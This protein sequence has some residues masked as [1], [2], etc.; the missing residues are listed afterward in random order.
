[1]RFTPIYPWLYRLLA[2]TFPNCLWSGRGDRNWIAL[3]FDDG[4]HPEYTPKLLKV[5]ERYD[6]VASFFCLG[7]CVRENSDLVRE[8]YQRGHWLGLHGYKHTSFT[9][10]SRPELNKSLLLTKEAIATAT[11]IEPDRLIDVRPPNGLFSPAILKQLQQL[12]YR[13]VMW[14]LVSEDWLNPG[15]EIIRTRVINGVKNGAN[16]VLHDG[17]YGGGKDVAAVVADLIPALLDRGYQF[18]S[19]DD[20]WQQKL[21]PNNSQ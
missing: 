18:V 5:L 11:N 7:S 15:I 3:T 16:I 20:F 17:C 4:P 19:I 9:A 1:M 13:V 21:K 12:G 10:L 8:I 14:S 2:P 6:L